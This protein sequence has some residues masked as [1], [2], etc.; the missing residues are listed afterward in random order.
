MSDL[1]RD[2]GTWDG[3]AFQRLFD[4]LAARGVGVHGEADLVWS[5]QP[6]AVLDAGCGTGR[7]AV[8][9]AR[10]GVHVV[11]VDRDPSMLATARRLA[12][13]LAWVEADMTSVDLGERFDV[14]VMA[15]NVVLYT[16]PG[17]QRA[18]VG[19][20]A[21]HLAPAGRLIAGFRLGR[22]GAA[23]LGSYDDDCAAAGLEL[24]V[25]WATWD[26][27]PWRP[28]ADFAV[29]VHRRASEPPPAG[30]R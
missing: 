1:R 12:P 3:E 26:R 30:R 28:G 23:V 14:V 5:F 22:D 7:V 18:L 24:E 13:Q 9:L 16:P 21:R 15:G 27:A 19:G 10:R 8:E 11:G 2:D 25:R 6:T 17:T 29:A 4:R 20:C